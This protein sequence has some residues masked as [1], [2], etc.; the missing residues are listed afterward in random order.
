MKKQVRLYDVAMGPTLLVMLGVPLAIGAVA[1]GL[2][3]WLSIV[4]I[5]RS[6]AKR[7]REENRP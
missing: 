6:K 7:E 1:V 3:V 2:L 5:R 4:M